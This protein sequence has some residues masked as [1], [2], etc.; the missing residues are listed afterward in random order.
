MMI[1]EETVKQYVSRVREKYARAGRYAPS[2]LELYYRAV[3]DGHLPPHPAPR[4]P[5][6]RLQG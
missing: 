5:P 4:N 6:S 2:K 1:S 3:E